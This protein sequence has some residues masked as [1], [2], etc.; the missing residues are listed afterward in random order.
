[1]YSAS[2]SW[3]PG[4][5]P[6]LEVTRNPSP[7]ASATAATSPPRVNRLRGLTYLRAYT[8]LHILS[9]DSHSR[10]NSSSSGSTAPAPPRPPPPQRP[11]TTPRPSS[12]PS[13][14]GP[15]TD[16]GT[17]TGASTSPDTASAR[18]S[19]S[20]A[21]STFVARL[22]A[23]QNTRRL[24]APTLATTTQQS[25]TDALSARSSSQ[26]N[27]DSPNGWPPAVGG[28]TQTN[29][30]RIGNEPN[31]Q[32]AATTLPSV[33]LGS[34]PSAELLDHTP[35]MPR[36][37]SATAGVSTD[38]SPADGA[39]ESHSSE[40]VA[41]NEAGN[42]KGMSHQLPSIRF[43]AHQ[44]P[45]AT[46]P[47]LAFNPMARILPSG[48]EVIKVG[49]YSE[50]DTQPAQAANAPSAAPVGF[51]S[52]VVSRRHCEFWYSNGRWYIRDVKSSSGT[53]LNH[54]RLS[55][56]GTES[57]PYPVNDG[58]I[59]QLGIDFKGG[60][61]MIFRCVKIRIELN[62]GWQ[63]GPSS[64][65]VQSHKRLREL[66]SQG[67]PPTSGS[68]QDCS[69]CL[70]PIAPCQSLFVAPCSHTWHYKC[71]RVII[72]GPHWPHFVCPNCRSVA[73]LEAELDD[74]FANAGEWEE[75]PAIDTT[76]VPPEVSESSDNAA[77]RPQ[78]VNTT[79]A[80]EVLVQSSTG[81][82]D[83]GGQSDVAEASDD[84]QTSQGVDRLAEDIE[85]INIEGSPSS[86]TFTDSQLPQI[87]NSTVAPVDIISRK[88]VANQAS[89]TS[90]RLDQ[91][92][93]HGRSLTRTPSP[94]GASDS[95]DVTAGK[96][97]PMTPRNDAGPFIFDGSAGRPS[98]VR[99]ATIATM[100]LNAA[101][102]TPPSLLAPETTS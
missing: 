64:F 26:N 96:E 77:D 24:T 23:P 30:S 75:Q 2:A 44:D 97:G 3:H 71:I 49:R 35:T 10:S 56:P 93:P 14:T 54:I 81:G 38:M 51:K 33:S 25:V 84:S 27:T 67:K 55:L 22:P 70:G 34:T 39:A 20:S 88:P 57:K 43:T 15:G 73:D 6:T 95:L 60:E 48:S 63:N 9:R 80:T 42:A 19:S 87:S 94:N 85:D 72:N 86:S 100:N 40:A 98:D 65:N 53:F 13:T 61:E 90:S 92:D 7:P 11:S 4:P 1:M 37:R 47:S 102:N 28:Q 12:F 46:R 83:Q 62:K 69:I 78:E 79:D 89:G 18:G 74:P 76:P 82:S 58:D 32:T 59:V 101:A 99:M 5:S 91:P 21:S 8:Q 45:R 66:N 68:S 36:T 52:K 31:P 16:L 17:G 41:Q 50:R 29:L